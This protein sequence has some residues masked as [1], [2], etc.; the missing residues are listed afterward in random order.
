MENYIFH[1]TFLLLPRLIHL[2]SRY[3]QL[4]QHLREDGTGFPAQLTLTN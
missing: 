2:I 3:I 1:R 4:M